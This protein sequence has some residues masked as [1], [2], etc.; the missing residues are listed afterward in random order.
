MNGIKILVIGDIHAKTV[1]ESIV[2]KEK[3][4]D[5]VIFLGDYFDDFAMT[6]SEGQR[7]NFMK[8][9]T[10]KKTD[11]VRTVILIGNHDFHYNK[12]VNESYSG[13]RLSTRYQ[14]EDLIEQC[15]KEELWQVC[16]QHEDILFTH[17]G[18]SKFWCNTYDIDYHKENVAEQI[19]LLYQTRLSP[20]WF[21]RQGF[22]RSMYGDD[23]NQSPLWIRP[24]SLIKD[25]IPGFK[26]VVGHTHTSHVE[27]RSDFLWLCDTLNT[28]HQRTNDEYLIIRD[29]QFMPTVL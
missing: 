25:H 28:D 27:N 26:Q 5:K 10:L 3:D 7:T 20:F 19:N 18:I 22:T 23:I 8:L 1:W 16:H 11:P 14:V 12:N 4:Y 17:A 15:D 24:D 21:Q 29:K 13:Y 2:D 6:N 9:M